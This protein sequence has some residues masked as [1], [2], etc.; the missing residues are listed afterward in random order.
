MFP[1]WISHFTL[2]YAD[3]WN[4]F[5]IDF[6]LYLSLVWKAKHVYPPFPWSVLEIHAVMLR[7][8]V[9]WPCLFWPWGSVS[10]SVCSADNTEASVTLLQ[11]AF[12]KKP[13]RMSSVV[14]DLDVAFK[15]CPSGYFCKCVTATLASWHISITIISITV[16]LNNAILYAADNTTS[17]KKFSA[18]FRKLQFSWWCAIA[19]LSIPWVNKLLRKLALMCV[20]EHLTSTLPVWG[21]KKRSNW[22]FPRLNVTG[23][24]WCTGAWANCLFEWC[25]VA[26]VITSHSFPEHVFQ[27]KMWGNVNEWSWHIW[28]I[29]MTSK[30]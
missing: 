29:T 16:F 25:C 24:H 11:R 4:E 30:D 5:N 14:T 18:H 27:V 15:D 7:S 21:G 3:L 22:L 28:A 13:N 26:P 10:V 9:T 6:K 2:T 1:C 12:A 20:A 23:L 19:W 17:F 8:A